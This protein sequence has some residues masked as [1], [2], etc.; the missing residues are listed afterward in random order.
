MIEYKLLLIDAEL[1]YAR[2]KK[3]VKEIKLLYLPE[4]RLIV[5]D[6]RAEKNMRAGEVLVAL[7]WSIP[8][9]SQAGISIIAPPKHRAPPINPAKNP[10]I[11]LLIIFFLDILS[12]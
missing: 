7:T 8:E 4:S 1:M 5:K 10:E 12:A 6:T 3:N 9:F 11:I 2:P